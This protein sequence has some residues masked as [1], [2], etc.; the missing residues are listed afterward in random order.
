MTTV[1]YDSIGE[2]S[3]KMLKRFGLLVTIPGNN[4]SPIVAY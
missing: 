2:C 1:P 3:A 4:E